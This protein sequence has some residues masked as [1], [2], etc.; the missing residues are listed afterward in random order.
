MDTPGA[1]D[2]EEYKYLSLLEV[3]FYPYGLIFR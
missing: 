2:G 1:D 3:K